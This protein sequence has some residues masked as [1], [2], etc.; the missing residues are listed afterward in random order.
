MSRPVTAPLSALTLGAAVLD[1]SGSILAAND[2]FARLAGAD[3][4][5]LSGRPF[6]EEFAAAVAVREHAKSF[7][8]ASGPLEVDL[9]V[10]AFG[11][12]LGD[13]RI[14]MRA[15]DAG[16]RRR[17]L[18]L[19]EEGSEIMRLRSVE[20]SYDRALKLVSHARHEIN[21]SLMGILGHLEILLS[22][23]GVPDSIRKRA[24]ILLEESERIRDCVAELDSVRKR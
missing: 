5:S 9:Q 16:S 4:R 12:A 13:F 8:E 24:E 2:A 23:A 7:L 17:A 11:A 1:A 14:R 22:Q 3:G 19:V 6:F 15:F 18:V 20:S 10:P 21:N